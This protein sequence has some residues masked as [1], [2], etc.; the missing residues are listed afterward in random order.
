MLNVTVP[1]PILNTDNDLRLKISRK[2]ADDTKQFMMV[3]TKVLETVKFS[4]VDR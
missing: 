4:K 3:K 2:F 1:R